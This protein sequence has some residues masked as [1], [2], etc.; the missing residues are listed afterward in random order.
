MASPT[1]P[2]VLQLRHID[3]AF[4]GVKALSGIDLDIAPAEIRAVIGPNGAGKSS[5][6]NVVCGLYR[7]DRGRIR[8]DGAE[9]THVP[10]HR[11]ARLGV[12][13]TFQNLALF[14]GL[15]VRDNVALG[16]TAPQGTWIGQWAG[17]PGA[18]EARRQAI[19]Q[20][21]AVLS[22]LDLQAVRDRPAATLPYGLQKRV[23]LARALVAAPRLLLLDEPMAGM[24]LAEKRDMARLV[25][26]ARDRFGTAIL[27]IEHDIGVVLG[28]SDRVAVLDHGR[29]IADGTPAEVRSDPA[30]IDA[31]LGV[32]HATEDG[33]GA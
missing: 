13:R 7:P 15:S 3:L 8:L 19:A 9:F 25:R 30:V 5:L 24:T 10:T 14:R 23:E 29:K 28:L 31:Y 32:E 18:R 4:G 22:F 21:D 12:A 11:P 17:W 16:C 33:G 1:P 27:L 26:A 2:P 6:V 20:A